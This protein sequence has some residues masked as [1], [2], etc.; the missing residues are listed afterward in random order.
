EPA[1][2]GLVRILNGKCGGTYGFVSSHAANT[3]GMATFLSLVFRR[4]WLGAGLFFWAVL[5]SYSRAYLGVHYP[6][7]L[8]C[9]GLMGAGMGAALW[10]IYLR[11]DRA[12]NGS[13][14]V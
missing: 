14:S 6:L 11:T 7:D 4:P 13:L 9:G 5:V 12:V 1:L 10:I 8:L 3:F 2:E